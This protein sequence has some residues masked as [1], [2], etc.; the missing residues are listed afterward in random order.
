[1]ERT[2][3][4]SGKKAYFSVHYF[5]FSRQK[6]HTNLLLKAEIQFCKANHNTYSEI[7]F[8][9]SSFFIHHMKIVQIKIV[10]LTE[11]SILDRVAIFL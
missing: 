1:M 10:G 5:D 6:Y 8:P 3:H 4:R 7:I 2:E 11:I 9:C